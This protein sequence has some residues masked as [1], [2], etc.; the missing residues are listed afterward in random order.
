M[1][2]C[3]LCLWS[4]NPVVQVPYVWNKFSMG[5]NLNIPALWGKKQTMNYVIS[6]CFD[7]SLA[8]LLS[9]SWSS[10]GQYCRVVKESGSYVE[11]ACSHMS[12]YAAH[13]EFAALAS[14]NEAFFASGF[15]CIS[16]IK[17]LTYKRFIFLDFSSTHLLFGCLIIHICH[18]G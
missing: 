9:S 6:T 2:E 17:D 14:Y 7:L 11:C 12:I 18:N 4:I 16:G 1:Q 3:F 15:I 13:A 10:D 5:W 8:S